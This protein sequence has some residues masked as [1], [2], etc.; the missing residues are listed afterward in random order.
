MRN[1]NISNFIDGS[2]FVLY[3]CD[4][5]HKKISEWMMFAC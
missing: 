2:Y 3:T 5:K 4:Y 1:N